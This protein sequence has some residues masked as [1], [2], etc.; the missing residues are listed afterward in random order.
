[1]PLT[2][3]AHS[4]DGVTVV[5]AH[6]LTRA[7]DP[8]WELMMMMP[9]LGERMQNDMWRQTLRNLAKRF[10]VDTVAES[11]IVCV[12]NRRQWRNAKNAWQNAGVRAALSAPLRLARRLAAR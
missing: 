12:D 6:E 5:Q 11:K 9:V 10:G 1:G 2:F 7:S 3:S 4:D 8:L